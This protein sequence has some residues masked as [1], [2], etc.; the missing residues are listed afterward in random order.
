VAKVGYGIDFGTTNSVVSSVASDDGEAF[1]YLENG[2]PHPSVV[3]YSIDHDPIVGRRARENFHQYV[4]A[5]GNRFIRSVKRM[6]GKGHSYELVGEPRD[7]WEVASEIFAHLKRTV[8]RA[9]GSD[10]LREA[11]VTIPIHFDGR[12]RNELRRGARAAGIEITTFI[13]EP[14]AAVVGY[15]RS[16]GA[17]LASA[18]P[19]RILV[20]DW[21]GG[22]LDVTLVRVA[23]GR[24][25][26]LATGGIGDIAGD[27]FDDAI[28]KWAI[29][30]FVDRVGIS[31]EEVRLPSRAKDVLSIESE[32]AKIRL[33]STQQTVLLTP[34]VAERDGE[35]FDLEETLDRPTFEGLIGP[36]LRRALREMDGVI[37]S[38]R[39]TVAEIDRV[40]LIGGS[41][42]IPLLRSE[43]ARR[44][45]SRVVAIQRSQTIIADG[46]AEV[47]Y[48][49]YQPYLVN[50]IVLR[51]VDRSEVTILD[52]QTLLP[53][54]VD[55]NRTLVCT[56]P[57]DGTARLVIA[58][59]PVESGPRES[60]QAGILSVPVQ[61]GLPKPFSNERIHAK[62]AIDDDL[63]LRVLASGAA[64]GEVARMDL[65]DLRFGLRTR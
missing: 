9:T 52:R 49:G 43:M 13:H 46:A 65:Y 58:E 37:E 22:T 40:L 21:G 31:P 53:T 54:R 32:A 50:S 23:D 3:W 7:A 44:F 59:R 17:D 60:V 25:E 2:Q 19:E 24:L 39:L 18:P 62:F 4:D 36:D 47:A 28:G 61:E 5:P 27:H 42:S 14:F 56:D 8:M 51:L 48:R 15:Y 63:I 64:T 30:R 35:V 26:E 6:L 29:G 10:D 11:V 55:V 1:A 34:R 12:A 20:F 57:R 16:Q 41:S 33:S 45:G 38:A